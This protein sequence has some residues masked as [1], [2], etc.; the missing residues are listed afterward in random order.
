M[1]TGDTEW[2][3]DLLYDKYQRVRR[4]P[5]YIEF[6]THIS[7]NKDGF[8]ESIYSIPASQHMKYEELCGRLGLQL[9]FDPLLE[10]PRSDFLQFPIFKNQLAV[11]CKMHIENTDARQGAEANDID[12]QPYVL[13]P[14]WDDHYIILKINVSPDVRT[15]EILRE[16]QESVISAKN[17][18][19]SQRGEKERLHFK[20]RLA[21]YKIYDLR[22]ERTPFRD[23]AVKLKMRLDEAK[24]NFRSAYSLITGKVY[25]KPTWLEMLRTT[26]K[27]KVA[28]TPSDPEAWQDLAKMEERYQREITVPTERFSDN[29]ISGI[30]EHTIRALTLEQALN[31]C[32]QCRDT[33]CYNAFLQG[34]D[35]WDPCPD[36]ARKFDETYS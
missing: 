6:C 15:A 20:A 19:I 35:D 18:L 14:I 27:Q 32:K 13:T 7:F 25:D 11:E 23:V 17:L 5:E 10:I 21:S 2:I 12:A 1:G 36:I 31:I 29:D 26:L 16:V 30:E 4:N 34:Q 3:L 33:E 9:I 28:K 8:L 22:K 24:V